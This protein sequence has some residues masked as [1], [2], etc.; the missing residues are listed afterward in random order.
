MVHRVGRTAR[1][2]RSGSAL[3]FLMCHET[4]YIDFLRVRKVHLSPLHSQSAAHDIMSPLSN[5]IVSA[6]LYRSGVNMA[7][8]LRSTSPSLCMSAKSSTP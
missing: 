5:N 7:S 4:A 2:G 8:C 6:S 1:M 3:I